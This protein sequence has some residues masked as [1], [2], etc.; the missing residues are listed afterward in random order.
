MKILYCYLAYSREWPLLRNLPKISL[1]EGSP[2]NR[3]DLRAV[4][5]NLCR[6]C[7]LLSSKPPDKLEPV[8]ADKE[9]VMA[10]LNIRSMEF[11][12]DEIEQEIK[13]EDNDSNRNN[14]VNILLDLS[15]VT[16]I[17]YLDEHEIH[18][19]DNLELQKT[20]PFAT[21]MAMARGILDS[22]M[23][24]TYFNA[25]ALRLLR[26]LVT[27]MITIKVLLRTPSV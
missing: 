1:V 8:L 3:A 11:K 23:S 13:G 17:R 12:E 20:L 15:F 25:S 14:S 6:T 27:G 7:I 4:N 10:A 9:I 5:V 18:L 24:A 2:L 26:L 16:N 19:S 21:G 22:L